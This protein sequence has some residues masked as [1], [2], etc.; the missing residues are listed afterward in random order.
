MQRESVNLL[1][2]STKNKA[3]FGFFGLESLNKSILTGLSLYR[4]SDYE[5]SKQQA[6]GVCDFTCFDNL[7]PRL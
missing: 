1:A 2:R 3:V 5:E 7:R 4:G 6:T